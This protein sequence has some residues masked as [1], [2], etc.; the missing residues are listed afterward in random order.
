MTIVEPQAFRARRVVSN[1]LSLTRLDRAVARS[2]AGFGIA[3]F[4]QSIPFMMVQASNLDRVWFAAAIGS[5]S[6]ALL[7]VL[8]CSVVARRVR[9][10]HGIF[11]AVYVVAM[12]TWPLAVIEPRKDTTSFFLYFTLTIATAMATIA[13][14]P[15]FAPLYIIAVPALYAWIRI[16]PAGGEVGILQA[17]LDSVYSLIL[18]G[19][20]A[21][22]IFVLRTAARRVDAAQATALARYSHAVRQHAIEA[23]RVQVD[24]IV[25]DS[26]LTT[27]LTAAR[28]EQPEAKALAGTMAANAIGHLRDAAAVG[29]DVE[30]EVGA[31]V[32]AGRIADA[33]STMA[34]SIGMRLS[35]PGFASLP[36]PV[37]EALY[38]AAVQAMVNS[39]QHAGRD[40]R[41]WVEV[42][43][44]GL[45][46]VAVEVGDLGVGFDTDAVP[47]ERLGVRV[48]ILERMVAVAGSAAVES[49][50]GSGTVVTLRWAPV[51]PEVQA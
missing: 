42:R 40:A 32:L 43:P 7:L 19:V 11:A 20:I 5:L 9:T 4:L 49:G 44:E 18:G 13:T 46:G 17:M 45:D 48:S 47:S 16:T 28:A 41:R 33:A 50:P 21:I 22:T 39:L 1:P 26:V 23:E 12:A 29:P 51:P 2:A 8:V 14:G 27:L 24:A 37:A 35:D 6:V 31:A 3:F 15:R 10:A 34:G 30:G 36:I 38:S 25:H